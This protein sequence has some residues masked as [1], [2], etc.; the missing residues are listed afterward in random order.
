MVQNTL[1]S[2]L[3]HL[4]HPVHPLHLSQGPDNL[5]PIEINNPCEDE[6]CSPYS[7]Q[8]RGNHFRILP[9]NK[10]R[11]AARHSAAIRQRRYFESKINW[12]AKDDTQYVDYTWW[13]G[14]ICIWLLFVL[15]SY[16]WAQ[17]SNNTNTKAN[18]D[19]CMKAKPIQSH[20]FHIH[21]IFIGVVTLYRWMQFTKFKYA[22]KSLWE[23][24]TPWGITEIFF[25]FFIVDGECLKY[26]ENAFFLI[27][28]FQ[29]WRIEL[30]CI[31]ALLCSS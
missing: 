26:D 1:S 13:Q 15:N 29:I 30:F 8:C 18:A 22:N 24:A 28:V 23:H 6:I 17:Q 4:V 16:S 7:C 2:H 3:V 20:N 31:S 9:Q 11:G 21:A 10:K 25:I 27:L 14:T 12:N 19:T 5:L